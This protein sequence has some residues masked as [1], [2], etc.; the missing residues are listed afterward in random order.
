MKPLPPHEEVRDAFLAQRRLLA[1]GP[2]R[3]IVDGGAHLGETAARYR[4]AFPEAVVWSFEPAPES[5]GRLRAAFAD[6]PLVRPV[7]LALGREPGA[8]TLHLNRATGTHSLFRRPASGRR[9]YDPEGVPAGRTEVRVTSLDAF[10][11]ERGLERLD[12]L[13]LDVQGGELGALQ[14][15]ARLLREG[16]IGLVYAEVLFVHHYEGEPLFHEVAAFLEGLDYT[17]YG[18]YDLVFARDGQ[19]R[20]ADAIFIPAATRAALDEYEP[21][22]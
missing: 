20:F 3:T 12:V 21:E 6:D 4:E 19:L 18:L 15:A 7:N 5:F 2:V 8:A 16:R 14:G 17:L 1:G 11:A 10:T 22:Y 13:K 9:Y